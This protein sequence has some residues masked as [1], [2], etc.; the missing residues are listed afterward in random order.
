MKRGDSHRILVELSREIDIIGKLE[1]CF[2]GGTYIF[3]D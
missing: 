3:M 1:T 2:E